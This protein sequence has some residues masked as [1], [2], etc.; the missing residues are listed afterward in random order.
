MIKTKH[1]QLFIALVIL[2]VNS[3]AGMSQNSQSQ[4]FNANGVLDVIVKANQIFNIDII[5]HKLDKIIITSSLEGEYKSSYQ[6][7]SKIQDGKLEIALLKQPFAT[8]EDN[9]LGAHKVISAVLRIELPQQL[10]LSVSSDIGSVKLKGQF[11][12]VYI[13]LVHGQC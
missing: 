3:D 5:T 12:D 4:E 2:V 10:N 11:N 6:V 13:K 9:K 8:I 7:A 1:I